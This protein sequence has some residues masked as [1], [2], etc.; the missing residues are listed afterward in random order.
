MS[1]CRSLPTSLSVGRPGSTIEFYRTY[2]H[3]EFVRVVEVDTRNHPG[4]KRR[5]LRIESNSV[6]TDDPTLNVVKEIL[7]TVRPVRGL[8]AKISPDPA[9]PGGFLL[10]FVLRSEGKELPIKASG[11]DEFLPFLPDAQALPKHWLTSQRNEAVRM[12][13]ISAHA[14]SSD[15]QK[16]VMRFAK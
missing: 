7:R 9:T 6:T 11:Q 2:K 16:V 10:N 5:M 14:T 1:N 13:S 8:T 3:G 12:S 15:L 4:G